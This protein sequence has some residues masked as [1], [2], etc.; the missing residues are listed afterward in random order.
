LARLTVG[1]GHR[2]FLPASLLIGALLVSLA[3]A[4]AKTLIPGVLLPVGIVT[5]LIGLPVFFVL[6]ARVA[7]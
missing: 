4:A 3:S 1:D 6:I 2:H 5:S 7:R